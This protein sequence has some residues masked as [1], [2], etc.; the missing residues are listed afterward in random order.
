MLAAP[1]QDWALYE[2]RSRPEHI[3]WLR[4]LTPADVLDLYEDF[5]RLARAQ[6]RPDE[7]LERIEQIHWAEKVALRRKLHAAFAAMDRLR[8]ATTP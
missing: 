4:R 7:G 3:D 6:T 2:R 1:R 8:D 5:Y